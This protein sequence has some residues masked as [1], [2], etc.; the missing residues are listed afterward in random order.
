MNKFQRI[1]TQAGMKQKLEEF[2][3]SLAWVERLD[4]TNHPAPAAP[5]MELEGDADIHND[6]TRE[7]RL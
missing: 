7:L 4:L 6:F 1:S 2:H 3:K 5:G